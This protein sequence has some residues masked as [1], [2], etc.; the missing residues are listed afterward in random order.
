ML[1]F[2]GTHLISQTLVDLDAKMERMMALFQTLKTTKEKDL[3]K[4]INL[5][6]GPKKCES[7]KDILKELNEYERTATEP[8]AHLPGAVKSTKLYDLNDL[9]KDLGVDPAEAISK[10]LVLFTRKFEVQKSQLV[11]NV[12]RIVTRES[13]R[14]VSVV[15]KMV[16]GP[17]DKIV[18]RVSS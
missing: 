14:L 9:K 3:T 11:D 13:D 12:D 1:S 4:L 8:L 6:G 5:K 7:D 10:N 16:S 2:L 17:G 18:D 15:T